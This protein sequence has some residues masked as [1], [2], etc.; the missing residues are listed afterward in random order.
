M[1]PAIRDGEACAPHLWR[2]RPGRDASHAT[3]AR[4]AVLACGLYLTK[5]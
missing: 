3:L 1:S 5:G 2:Y 4:V